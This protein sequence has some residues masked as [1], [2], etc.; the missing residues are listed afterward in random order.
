MEARA[1]ELV[2]AWDI[3]VI[4]RHKPSNGIDYNLR[5]IRSPLARFCVDNSENVSVFVRD[6]FRRMDE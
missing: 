6:P 2:H 1:L 4:R 3:G 5:L